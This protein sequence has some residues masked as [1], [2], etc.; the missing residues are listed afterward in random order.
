MGWERENVIVSPRLSEPSV[1]T[2]PG[3]KII[4]IWPGLGNTSS[5]KYQSVVVLEMHPHRIE[6]IE[7]RSHR[8]FIYILFL[9]FPL[10]FLSFASLESKLQSTATFNILR[11]SWSPKLKF[12]IWGW[13]NQ[14][15]NLY[16][17]YIKTQMWAVG[18]PGGWLVGWLINYIATLWH[19]LQSETC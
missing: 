4:N 11:L 16:M 2:K 15:I 3:N 8:A 19:I 12:K 6:K 14:P 1:Q 5:K 10:Y 18:W 9:F 17:E 13:S 7:W